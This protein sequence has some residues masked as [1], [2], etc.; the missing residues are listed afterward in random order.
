MGE[1]V[2]GLVRRVDGKVDEIR[3]L[4]KDVFLT[5]DEYLLVRKV[6]RVV[7]EKRLEELLPLDGF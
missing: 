7:R 5:P 6:D 2:L 1:S 3:E 4:L